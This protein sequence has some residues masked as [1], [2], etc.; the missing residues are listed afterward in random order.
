MSA[1]WQWHKSC[2]TSANAVAYS[3]KS[4]SNILQLILDYDAD[5]VLAAL[6]EFVEPEILVQALLR[7][8]SSGLTRV[9]SQLRRTRV[10]QLVLT[11]LSR[12]STLVGQLLI[13]SD[14]SK[15]LVGHARMTG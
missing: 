3:E 12:H 14:Q 7:E 11:I 5:Q 4:P 6:V 8:Y 10:G 2:P 9:N 15:A 1:Q 13:R